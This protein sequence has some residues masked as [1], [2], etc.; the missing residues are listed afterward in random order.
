MNDVQGAVTLTHYKQY[1]QYHI[2]RDTLE[3]VEVLIHYVEA[4]DQH[5]DVRTKPLDRKSLANPV[6]TL[7]NTN[8]KCQVGYGMG[9]NDV[10]PKGGREGKGRSMTKYTCQE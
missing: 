1:I 7:M 9:N 5:L 4:K 3:E 8:T 10:L 2:V 6:G